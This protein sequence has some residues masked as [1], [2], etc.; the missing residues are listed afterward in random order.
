[1]ACTVKKKESVRLAEDNETIEVLVANEY[2]QLFD[3]SNIIIEDK[4]HDLWDAHGGLTNDF[5]VDL[6]LTLQEEVK[7][8]NHL[9]RDA[10]LF[11]M[12]MISVKYLLDYDAAEMNQ[13]DLEQNLFFNSSPVSTSQIMD[14]MVSSSEDLADAIALNQSAGTINSDSYNQQ[15]RSAQAWSDEMTQKMVSN[16]INDLKAAE[17]SSVEDVVIILGE[18][19]YGINRKTD[20][21]NVSDM[22]RLGSTSGQER[23][24]RQPIFRG[25]Y[26]YR[27]I[28]PTH[29]DRVRHSHLALE[30]EGLNS[31]NIYNSDDPTWRLIIPPMYFNCRCGWDG[32]TLEQAANRGIQE[33]VNWLGRSTAFARDNDVSMQNAIITTMPDSFEFVNIPE[34]MLPQVWEERYI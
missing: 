8:K 12:F 10:F 20:I 31:T 30:A 6:Q 15:V 9:L 33:A 34:E 5:F 23:I 32:V 19:K 1:M 11:S 2:S 24:L 14:A 4:V 16:A 28:F 7:R 29:D 26:P 22:V 21:D 18:T 17:V 27:A 3:L 25:I 13:F